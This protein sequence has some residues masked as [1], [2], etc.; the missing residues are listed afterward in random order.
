MSSLSVDLSVNVNWNV[1][2]TYVSGKLTFSPIEIQSVSK[3]DTLTFIYTGKRDSE[4]ELDIKTKELSSAN[5]LSE[6]C[7]DS[8]VSLKVG[9][10]I[11]YKVVIDKSKGLLIKKTK[12]S[13]ACTSE[14]TIVVEDIG[15][16][17]DGDCDSGQHPAS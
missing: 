8:I 3:G 13:N 16:D 15:D 11:T 10:P 2:I 12:A 6:I 4:V 9:D 17:G 7:D 1:N 14:G 5:K